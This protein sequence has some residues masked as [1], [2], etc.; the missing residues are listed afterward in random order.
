MQPTDLAEEAASALNQ[1][2]RMRGRLGSRNNPTAA[3]ADNSM[4]SILTFESTHADHTDASA[5]RAWLEN[6]DEAAAEWLFEKYLPLVRHICSRKL[7]RPWIIEDAAEDTMS[8]AFLA[9]CGFDAERSFSSWIGSIAAHVC[10]DKLRSLSRRAEVPLNDIDI[11]AEDA[12]ECNRSEQLSAV[13]EL[14]DSMPPR[15]R[16]VVEL[17]YFE[18]LTM[19]DVANRTGLTPANVAVRLMR[20]R[21]ALVERAARSVG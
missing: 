15:F 16:V 20:A 14:V 19:R 10:A 13:R 21:R 12:N 4:I 5:V 2:R 17:H 3:R 1:T 7:P 18:G 11:P 6:A 8:R 9:L